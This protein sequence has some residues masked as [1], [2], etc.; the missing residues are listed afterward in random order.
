MQ[1]VLLNGRPFNVE[2]DGLPKPIIVAGKKHFIGFSGLPQG[3]RPGYV[4][5]KGMKGEINK[6]VLIPGYNA[7]RAAKKASVIGMSAMPEPPSVPPGLLDNNDSNSEDCM[8]ITYGI[9]KPGEINIF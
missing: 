5:I 8:E 3:F 4:K 9:T 1:V 7:I 6:D 2:F